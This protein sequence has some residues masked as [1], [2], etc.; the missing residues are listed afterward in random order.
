MLRE[1]CVKMEIILQIPDFVI[2]PP[3]SDSDAV[4]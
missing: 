1:V 4:R 2:S 3:F